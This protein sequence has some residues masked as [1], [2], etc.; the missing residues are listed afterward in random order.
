[1]KAGLLKRWWGPLGLVLVLA[2][3]LFLR[4]PGLDRPAQLKLGS[5]YQ[6]ELKMLTNTVKVMKG[7]RLLPHWPYGIYRLMTPQ[8]QAA[9]II[10]TVRCGRSLLNPVSAA[11]LWRFANQQL[12]RFMILIRAHALALGLGIVVLTFVI[13]RRI[14]GDGGG[15]A[16]ALV[17]GIDPLMVSYSRMMYYDIAMVL[18]LLFY[19]I[20]FAKAW[21]ERSIGYLYVAV[22]LSA[23]A[24]TMKQNAGVLFLA[25]VW[26]LLVVL[27]D[28]HPWRLVTDRHTWLLAFMTLIIL[29]YGYPTMFTATGLEGFLDSLSSKY[30]GSSAAVSVTMEDRL[31]WRWISSIWIDQGPPIVLI[32]LLFGLVLGVGF[33]RDRHV[34]ATVLG[35]GALYCGIAGYS[36]H[37][38]DRTM[39]PLIPLLAIGMAGWVSM[40]QRLSP[41]RAAAATTAT[42]LAFI[43]VPLLQN[44]LR[45][46]LLVTLPDTRL[47]VVR[48]L[49][50]NAPPRAGVARE[51]YSPNLPTM[52]TLDCP[53]GIEH[54]VGDGKRFVVTY[55]NS[56]AKEPPDWYLKQG[57]RYLVYAPKNYDRLLRQQAE[58]YIESPTDT[59]AR[60]M[61]KT[62]RYGVMITEAIARYDSLAERYTV[63][64]RY[65]PSPPPRS[66]TRRCL[67]YAPPDANTEA[68]ADRSC[69]RPSIATWRDIAAILFTGWLDTD[70]LALW[71]DRDVYMLGPD[72]IIYDTGYSG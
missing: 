58:G 27:G 70:L 13:G 51:N 46:N 59:S 21:R 64:A 18:F 36:T 43:A 33:A 39:L 68:A 54:V 38:I 20:A 53:A 22:A 71:R 52:D 37:V 4:L 29:W 23:V 65:T 6:D 40:L 57:I 9:Q 69:G 45:A 8:F 17:V 41:S 34:A 10:Y 66:L 7:Q 19:I 28:R 67:V 16:A 12:D 31:W 62:P 60:R 72:M 49:A 61:G 63:A 32:V 30:Y 56:L 44:T 15:L 24:F 42:M 3:A 48:W 47:E 14:A 11:E 55:R 50:A 35:I 1:M 25:D 2:L 5:L 26:L